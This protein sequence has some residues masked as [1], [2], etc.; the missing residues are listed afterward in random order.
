MIVSR[1]ASRLGST[2]STSESTSTSELAS[3]S[4]LPRPPRAP[5]PSRTGSLQRWIEL[6]PHTIRIAVDLACVVALYDAW[7]ASGGPLRVIVVWMISLVV[8]PYSS[9]A[10]RIQR[11]REVHR[12]LL[13]TGVLLALL[14]LAGR[15]GLFATLRHYAPASD[16]LWLG[17]AMSFAGAAHVR[18]QPATAKPASVWRLACGSASVASGAIWVWLA[19]R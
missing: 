16:T 11:Q 4:E 7:Q 6:V 19:L 13:V 1:M 3:T 14:G 10:D 17:I 5:V 9:M 2:S 12:V 15:L 8:F 18:A